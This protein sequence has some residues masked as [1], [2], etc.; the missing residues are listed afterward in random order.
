MFN[1]TRNFFFIACL[2]N[3]LQIYKLKTYF[4]EMN[5]DNSKAHQKIKQKLKESIDNNRISH[6][7]LFAG[8]NGWGTLELAIEY[9]AEIMASEK[10]E[11]AKKKVRSEEHTSEL[12][13]RE[14]LV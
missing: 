12:Q 2:F 5:W 1:K 14:N 6:A 9:A 11:I 3:I 7:Q 13:S 10:G 4:W 8:K